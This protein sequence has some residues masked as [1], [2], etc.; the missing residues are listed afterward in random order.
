MFRLQLLHLKGD[1]MDF[2]FVRSSLSAEGYDVVYDINGTV[3][4]LFYI[5]M[6]SLFPSCCKQFF[7][8]E[9]YFLFPP[10]FLVSYS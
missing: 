6:Y 9:V 3:G 7:L 5:S 4:V 8:V 2:D 10:P 1:R